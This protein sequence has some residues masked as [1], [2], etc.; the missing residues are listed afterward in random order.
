MSQSAVD[1]Q[2][3]VP[4]PVRASARRWTRG[5]RHAAYAWGLFFSLEHAY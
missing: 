1:P 5:M 3:Q 2:P 4:T